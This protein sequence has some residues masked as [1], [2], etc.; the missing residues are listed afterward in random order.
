MT[1]DKHELL[2]QSVLEIRKLRADL[3]AARAARTEPIAIVGMACRLPGGAADPDDYWQFLRAGGDGIGDIP[4]SR[5][6]MKGFYDPSP[7]APGRANT[8]RAGLLPEVDRF[9][10]PFFGIAPR[11]AAAMDPQQRLLLELGWEALEHAGLRPDGLT[12]TPTGVFLGVTNNDYGQLQAQQ[13]DP[14]DLEAYTL[15]SAASTFAAGRLSYWLGL[16]GPSLSVDTACSSSLVAVHLACQSLHTGES[17]TALAGGANV[18]LAPEWFVVLSKAKMLAPDGRCKTFDAAADGYVRGEGAG[19]VVLK[20]LSDALADGDRIWAVVRGSAVNHDGRSSGITVPNAAAQREVVRRA[21]AAADIPAHHVGYVEAHGTGTPLGDPIELRALDAVFGDRAGRDPLLVGSVKTNIGHLE[22]AAGIAG[23]IKVAL[24]LHHAEIP[25]HLHLTEVNPA[26]GMDDLNL[27][28]PTEVTAWPNGEHRRAA[29]LSSFGASGTN[30][31]VIL[32]QAPEPEPV[33]AGPE[34][35]SHV[36]TLSAKSSA[37]LSAL[38]ERYRDRLSEMADDELADVCFTANT[39]RAAFAHRLALSGPTA[40]SLHE[41]LSDVAEGGMPSSAYTA[42]VPAGSKAKVVFL[43][44]GQGAQYPGMARELDATEPVFRAALDECDEVLAPLLGR[45]LRSV[46]DPAPH[47]ADLVHETR[48]TQP[49][50]FAV[51]YAL[52]ALWRSWGVEPAAVLGHSLGELVAACVAGVLDL[53]DALRLAARRGQLMQDLGDGGAMASVFA[54][55][56]SVRAVLEP[57][58]GEVSI[59]AVNGPE[60]VV[61]SGAEDAV[62]QVLAVL[63]EQGIRAKPVAVSRAF[64]SP[65]MDPMLAAFEAEAS[66]VEYHAA[67]IP[68]VSNVSGEVLLGENVYSAAYLREH[69][70]APVAFHAGMTAL[71]DAGHRVFVEIGP[72]PTLTGMAKR[73]APPGEPERPL[74]FL[75]SLR[76][77]HSDWQVLTDSLARLHTVGV[78]V[79]WATFDAGRG[80][81]R[82]TVPTYPFQRSRQ[83]FE[84]TEPTVVRAVAAAPTGSVDLLGDL[85]SSPLAQTQFDAVLDPETHPCLN[86]CM[87]DGL[88]V[89]NIG[90]YL[91]TVFAASARLGGTGAVA[92]T[93][94]LVLTSLVLEHGERKRVQLVVEPGVDGASTFGYHAEHRAENGGSFWTL[95]ASGAFRAHTVAAGTLD[96]D[97]VRGRLTGELSDVDF[98]RRM[99]RRRVYLGDSARWIEHVWCEPG[100]ALARMRAPRPGECAPYLLH[101]GLIDAMFQTVFSCL[102]AETPRDAVFMLVGMERFV[103]HGY[104]PDQTTYCHVRLAPTSDPSSTLAATVRLYDATGRAVAEA[105][106]VYLK[107]AQRSTL[108]RSA[109]SPQSPPVRP[110]AVVRTEPAGH[111]LAQVPAAER[112]GHL[113]VEFARLIGRALGSRGED[114]DVHEPLP[115]L[116]LDSLMA[117]EVKD[118]MAVELGITLPLVAFLEGRS[119]A[120]LAEEAIALLGGASEEQPHPAAGLPAITADEAARHDPFPLTDLQQAYLLGRSEVFELGGVSTYFFLEV[121]VEVD[122]ERLDAAL[123]R[124]ITRHDMLRAV[125]SPDGTQRVLPEVP[126]YRIDVTDL[127]DLP[128]NEREHALAA[129]HAEV[130]DQVFDPAVW[131]LFVVRATRLTDESARLHIGLDALI[132]DAWSTSVF[133]REWAAAYRGEDGDLPPLEITYR[134][135]VTTAKSI[136]GTP[137]HDAAERYWRERVETLPPAPD[138]PLATSPAAISA[139]RFAHRSTRLDPSVWAA[140]KRHASARGVTASAALCTAYSQVLA[141]WSK[142]GSFTLNVLFFNRLPLHEQVPDVVGNFS[143]TTLLEVHCGAGE[144]FTAQAERVQRRLWTDLEH[145]H[146][147]GVAV[148]RELNRVRG[149]A[150]SAGMPVVF[151]SMVNFASSENDPAATG[152]AQHLIELGERGTQV[153]SSIRTPQV[154]LDHQVVEDQGGLAVNWDVVEDLFPEGMV[155]AMFGAYVDLLRRLCHDEAAWDAATPVLVPAADLE[156]RGRVN[157]T[158]GPRP[159]GLLHEPIA[160]AAAERPDA[161][162]VIAADRTLSYGQLDQAANRV[163]HWLREHGVGAGD[164]VAVVMEKGWEQVVGVLG[165]LRAGA[166]YVPVDA[167]VPTERLH[168]L[169]ALC[170]GSVLLTQSW[171]EDRVDWPGDA[172]R[173]AVDGP[174]AQQPAD[175]P[176]PTTTEPTDLAYVIFTSGSTGTPKGVMIE[177][178]AALNT[179]V[180]VNERFGVTGDDR[181]LGLSALNFDLS[182]YDVF[183]VLGVGGALVLPEPQALREPARWAELVAEHRVTVWNTVPTLM[184]MFT[185]HALAAEVDALPVRVVMMSGDWIPVTLPDRIRTLLPDAGV[186]SLG[187]ATEAAI[188]SIWYPIDRV[189]PRWTSIPYG[190]PMRNQRFHV[191]DEQMRPCPVWVPGQLHIAGAGLARGYLGDRAKTDASFVRHPV[192]GERLY[193]TGDLGRYLPDGTIEFLGRE[194]FQ[195]KIN[196]YR[197]ELGEVDA[198]LLRQPGVRAA[199]AAAVGDRHTRRLVAYAVG[200]VT[201][202]GLLAG[203]RAQLPDYLVPSRV[204]I[205]DSL[206]LS[207]NGKVDRAA[208]PSPDAPASGATDA[209]GPRDAVEARLVEVWS[210]FFPGS[211]VGVASDFFALG[212]NSLLAV[213]LV[214]RVRAEFGRALPLSELFGRP[215]IEGLAERLRDVKAETGRDALVPIRT[216][217]TQPPL[218]LVHPVGGDVLC[219]AALAD[220]LGADQPCYGLQVPDADVPLG[221]VPDLARHYVAALTAAIPTGPYRVGGWSMGGMV[222]LEIARQLSDAGHEVDLVA[223]IDLLEPPGSGP[224][225]EVD[226]PQLLSWFARD[227]AG[228][229]GRSWAPAPESFPG[230]SAEALRVLH[231][232]AC[233]EQVLP[234]DIDSETL[235]AIF[236]RFARNYR[237]LLAY[238]PAPYPGRVLLVRAEQGASPDVTQAWLDLVPGD[239]HCVAVPGDHYSVMRAPQVTAL[240]DRLRAA[241]LPVLPTVEGSR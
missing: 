105:E 38:V 241:L 42:H 89:V 187:G 63:A 104:E 150:G 227:L 154:W 20:R 107:R 100:E 153:S 176:L 137:V 82:A 8:R 50:L 116:G 24:S 202:S 172:V 113:R 58:G 12:G 53:R 208:L 65:R 84:P 37:A 14:V 34:R 76:P 39:G 4:E 10:A 223:V 67:R 99:W 97:A 11:E 48:Y 201:E 23:L 119:I 174:E 199:V 74:V 117:L 31:H 26:I 98:H 230:G 59:A 211:E 240:A 118:A 148:L 158:A 94:S 175:D 182:V 181:V 177:H 149:T 169:L 54:S 93:D 86:D 194:D 193:R 147:S 90:V 120:G 68:L 43:F 210:E 91:D 69:A 235:G 101:P 61:V 131:P 224:G 220:A 81:R 140:F 103:F 159:R 2:V 222:A 234:S 183:G 110:A 47:E 232:R 237:A 51:E 45:R 207:A 203:L 162:A 219:Y 132:I 238:N 28:I 3:D 78:E 71:Y 127:R 212:G 72:A 73:F 29:G 142:S 166:A 204:V 35:T 161:P 218:L 221:T 217:G 125:V 25:P 163:A 143:A 171:V 36:L 139:P 57:W 111:V 165:V 236:E 198:A 129:I 109:P 77:R 5:W 152:L 225:R 87:V 85:V 214:S 196:G 83:W 17:D 215:T 130:R 79:D 46:L 122:L 128:E 157:D 1:D 112:S 239:A 64:H 145:S 155:D 55:A 32:E 33:P 141:A 184:E 197:I 30:A 92:V 22:P 138:L 134:D 60:S 52:A 186:W 96:L 6:D 213:R 233:A 41:S 49:A 144:A 136:A 7:G 195:V 178:A 44:T 18:L 66:T 190:T 124:M 27:R 216:G 126:D 133:L 167:G 189:D 228:L 75:P 226:D 188:W 56:E 95:H 170:G 192:T 108:L 21:L 80:R 88:P 123:R 62:A 229:A 168:T 19:M 9:D 179:V 180:D 70:R 156:I 185:E 206:P 146:V 209:T 13:V 135:Y 200:D 231:T 151:A 114:L 205:V 16:S 102:P 173:L 164:L 121:D 106:G 115:H 160:S 15:T 191:L 40:K